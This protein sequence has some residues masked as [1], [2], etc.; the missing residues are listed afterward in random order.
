MYICP[1]VKR[2]FGLEIPIHLNYVRQIEFPQSFKSIAFLF[3]DVPL[4]CI[5]EIKKNSPRLPQH[6]GQ[7]NFTAAGVFFTN[8]GL[9]QRPRHSSARSQK[10]LYQYWNSRLKIEIVVCLI[11]GLNSLITCPVL[12]QCSG[13]FLHNL[14]E[15]FC[16]LKSGPRMHPKTFLNCFVLNTL[17][18]KAKQ[19]RNVLGC[20]IVKWT[21]LNGSELNSRT[22][23]TVN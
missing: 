9:V 17:S 15:G 6:F 23:M 4:K 22:R 1:V 19:L 10:K 11:R 20:I 16:M 13:S 3:F 8:S 14:K 12:R 18:S 2:F 7:S 5:S 21:K